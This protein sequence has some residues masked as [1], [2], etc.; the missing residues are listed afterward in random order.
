VTP[1][2]LVTFYLLINS[3]YL[4]S[5]FGEIIIP[6]I[7]NNEVLAL[8]SLGYNISVYQSSHWIKIIKPVNTRLVENLLE[9]LD[10]GEAEAIALAKEIMPDYLL[11]DERK[12]YKN[13]C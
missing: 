11:I 12:A 6:P 13:S 7:V 3:I 5:F 2:P 9:E 4:K 1:L 8:Q 10:G